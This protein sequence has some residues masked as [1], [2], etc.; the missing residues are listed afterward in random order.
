[1]VF[2][3]ARYWVPYFQ[4]KKKLRNEYLIFNSFRL[5]VERILIFHGDID[6]FQFFFTNLLTC[7]SPGD[8]VSEVFAGG[9]IPCGNFVT[10]NWKCSICHDHLPYWCIGSESYLK[11]KMK[12][13]PVPVG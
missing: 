8:S 9:V 13:E 2:H 10:R 7:A 6:R 3:R 1:M 5:L 4:K 12:E 11:E